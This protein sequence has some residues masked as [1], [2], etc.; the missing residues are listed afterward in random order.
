ML[1]LLTIEGIILIVGLIAPMPIVFYV[2]VHGVTDWSVRPALN[3]IT[4]IVF[5]VQDGKWLSEADFK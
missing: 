2:F 5:P 3:R 4:S 1:R